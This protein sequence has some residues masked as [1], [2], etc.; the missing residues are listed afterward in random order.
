[1]S[2]FGGPQHSD[3]VQP[4][5]PPLQIQLPEARGWTPAAGASMS[6][7][8]RMTNVALEL[9]AHHFGRRRTDRRGTNGLARAPRFGQ[10]LT[11]RL[12]GSLAGGYTQNDLLASALSWIEQ[13]PHRLGYCFAAA[14]VRRTLQCAAWIYAA[15]SGLQHCCR[16][17]G[18]L[19]TR[20][21]NLFRSPISSPD[22]WEGNLWLTI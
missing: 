20:I 14:T 7:Q 18:E 22:R 13:W 11:R 1:M 10:Q 4:P 15:A 6:W 19:R 21:A 17:G 2:F 5:I 9:L 16:P 12:S 8:G 3:T